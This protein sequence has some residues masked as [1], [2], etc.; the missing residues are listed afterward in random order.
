MQL[1][2]LEKIKD[3]LRMICSY[4]YKYICRNTKE[5]SCWTTFNE[6]INVRLYFRR[7]EGYNTKENIFV[8]TNIRNSSGF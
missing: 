1:F 4:N 7:Y 6:K 5:I 8:D 3:D 2:N